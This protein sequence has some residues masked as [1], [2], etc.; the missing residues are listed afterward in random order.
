MNAIKHKNKAGQARR[1]LAVIR[2]R[3]EARKV[4]PAKHVIVCCGLGVA[5]DAVS[6]WVL[7]LPEDAVV[8]DEFEYAYDYTFH[9]ERIKEL[10][11]A[12]VIGKCGNVEAQLAQLA[13]LSAATS[14]LLLIGKGEVMTAL[15][16]DDR[17]V[18]TLVW[19]GTGE[20]ALTTVQRCREVGVK[21]V[22]CPDV[23]D[24]CDK[25]GRVFALLRY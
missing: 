10:L 25:W 8:D 17:R 12:D 24:W 11:F 19:F 1:V 2:E 3:L 22:K 18:G 21:I 23:P 5:D 7:D 14:P 20:I 16:A 4:Q 15:A 6:C 9:V 13:K